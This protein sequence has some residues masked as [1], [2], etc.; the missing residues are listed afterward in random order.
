MKRTEVTRAEFDAACDALWTELQYQDNLQRRT[1][2]EAK[3]VPGFVTLGRRYVRLLEDA[4]ADNPGTVQDN[5]TVQVEEALNGLRKVAAIFVR[6]MVY[7][8]VRERK[9]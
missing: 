7:N 4:W 8:G 3:D 1:D 9:I 2:D 6:A 5:G